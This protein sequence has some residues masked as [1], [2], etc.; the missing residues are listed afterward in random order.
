MATLYLIE[1]NTILRKSGDRVL[2]CSKPPGTRTTSHV[3]QK[4]IQLEIPCADIDQ[5]MLFGN[6]QVTTQALQE[7]LEHDIELAIFSYTGKLLGQLT[8]PKA[9][10]IELRLKQFEKYHDQHFCLSFSQKLVQNKI[11]S[12]L[13]NVRNY[14]KNYPGVF[15]SHDLETFKNFQ[16]KIQS[17]DNLDSLRGYEGSGSAFYFKLFGRM[18]KPPWSFDHRS[19]RPPEDPVNSVLSFGY[20]VVTTEIQ[21]LLDG[22]GFDPYLGFYHQLRYGRQGLA[23]DLVEEYRHSL[24]DRLALK[25]FNTGVFTKNDFYKPSTGGIYMNTSGKKK[26]FTHYEKVLGKLDDEFS[27]DIPEKGFRHRFQQH[28]SELARKIE[29]Q[30]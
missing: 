10:N 17:A 16:E 14:H 28:L 5:V 1:Q 18:F 29:E 3:S 13:D 27:P 23:L 7:L 6:I 26:F 19:R 2:L 4:E 8:P 25:L 30:D 22:I 15:S 11:Q 12:A 24:V 9:K 20:V 21:S